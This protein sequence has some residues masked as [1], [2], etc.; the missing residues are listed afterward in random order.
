MFESR[1]RVAVFLPAAKGSFL[2]RVTSDV[3]R[4]DAYAAKRR[5]LWGI[6]EKSFK[7]R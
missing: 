7:Q 2:I 1:E 5:M 6:V 4:S 3:E